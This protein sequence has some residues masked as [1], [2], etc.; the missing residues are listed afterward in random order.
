MATRRGPEDRPDPVGVATGINWPDA[1]AGGAL[2]GLLNGPLMLTPGTATDFGLDALY[3]LG[4][5]AGPTREVLIFGGAGV[6]TDRQRDQARYWISGPLGAGF[7]NNPTDL[8]A[9][10]SGAGLRAAGTQTAQPRTAEE[11]AEAARTARVGLD[12]LR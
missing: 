6:V 7:V 8:A 5:S 11:A 2:M 4:Q 1:L 12:A 10:R 3:L 9:S